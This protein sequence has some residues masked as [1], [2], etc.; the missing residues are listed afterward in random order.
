MFNINEIKKE[1]Y[2]TKMLAYFSH[3]TS[4]NLYYTIEVLGGIYQFIIPTVEERKIMV[5]GMDEMD[6]PADAEYFD[7]IK[8]S[9]DL[10]TTSFYREMKGSE[11]IRW[12]QKSIESNDFTKVE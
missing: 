10:G 6:G 4:G 3:Y 1:L 12:I 2:K 7:I 8:L 11:L 5:G 9:G